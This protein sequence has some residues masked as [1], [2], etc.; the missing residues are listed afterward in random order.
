[1]EYQFQLG[2]QHIYREKKNRSD[3]F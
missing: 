1:V 2:P 3:L